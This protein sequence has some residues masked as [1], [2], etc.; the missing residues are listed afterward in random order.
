[1]TVAHVDVEREYFLGSMPPVYVINTALHQHE[2]NI[3]VIFLQCIRISWFTDIIKM[4]EKYIFRLVR[5]KHISMSKRLL[6]LTA[7]LLFCYETI[8]T[9]P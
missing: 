1:M 7:H 8:S 2:I 9:T 6:N 3:K 4:S 5:I